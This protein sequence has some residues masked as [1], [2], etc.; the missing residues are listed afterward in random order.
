MRAK[1]AEG[2]RLKRLATA[3]ANAFADWTWGGGGDPEDIPEVEER[4]KKA[5]RKLFDAIDSLT[6]ID[7]TPRIVADDHP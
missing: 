5:R 6:S 3:Y 1:T 2:R 4:L 7:L